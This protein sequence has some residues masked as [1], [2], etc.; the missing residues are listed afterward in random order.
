[1]N[2]AVTNKPQVYLDYAAATP[3]DARVASV[4]QP[5]LS[6]A[7]HNPSASYAAGRAASAALEA[8][9]SDLAA[10]LGAR[11][12]E[13]VFTSGSTEGTYLA[14]A[15]V[16]AAHPGSRVA[17]IATEHQ[18]VLSATEQAS[19]PG[20]SILVPV[21]NSGRLRPREIPR[22]VT[23]DT[24]LLAV[25][26]ANS[27]IGTVQNLAAISAQIALIRSDR[28]SRGVVMPLYLYSDASAAAGYLDLHVSR[29]GVDLMSLGGSKLYGPQQSGALYV[30]SGVVIR[31]VMSGGGQERGLRGG[32][33]S[34]A[35]AVGLSRALQL[36]Q[37]ER[38]SE[39]ARLGLLREQLHEGLVQALPDLIVN[40][41]LRYSLPHI[42][43]LTIPGVPGDQ[44][45][46]YLDQAGIQVATG[47]ACSESSEQPSHVLQA[48]GRT[49]AQARQSLRISMGRATTKKD[50]DHLLDVLPGIVVRL[51]ELN[52]T[53]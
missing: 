11:S 48:I 39:L 50:I 17:A 3:L 29:L 44:L 45:V 28:S 40:T 46:L 41:P 52:P 21:D 14:I 19:G 13:V 15:G 4:M 22:T 43:N 27:E 25:A 9:R 31:P 33:P 30:R 16:L 18:S 12:L 8:A 53:A 47:S 37:A 42:M 5:Y 35:V 1:M 2:D 6:S 7:F 36:A 34:V 49:P 24:V 51:R 26:Y 20:R 23:D 38:S 32:T 10:S